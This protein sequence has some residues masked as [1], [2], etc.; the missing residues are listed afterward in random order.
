MVLPT[1]SIPVVDE[2]AAC[3]TLPLV[4]GQDSDLKLVLSDALNAPPAE[5]G[6]CGHTLGGLP[7]VNERPH[8]GGGRGCVHYSGSAVPDRHDRPHN[9]HHGGRP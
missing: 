7:C 1:T 8:P 9:H 6:T 4:V 3:P 5:V 2:A